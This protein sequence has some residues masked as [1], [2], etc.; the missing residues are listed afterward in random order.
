VPYRV[1]LSDTGGET[2][3]RLVELGALDVE[4]SHGRGLAALFPD[5]VTPEQV[6]RALGVGST[7]RCRI[8][9]PRRCST[10]ELVQACWRLPR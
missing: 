4:S 8:R 9:L 10:L 1:D 6:A 7:K 2:L 3:D 5:T